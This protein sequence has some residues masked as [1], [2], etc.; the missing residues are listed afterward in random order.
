[1]NITFTPTPF[2]TVR[3]DV[4]CPADQ[5]GKA[6]RS[7]SAQAGRRGLGKRIS[8]RAH[9]FGRYARVGVI[10]RKA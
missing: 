4:V 3:A 10:Y 1:M 2:G 5:V 9:V 7:I 6:K 8:V